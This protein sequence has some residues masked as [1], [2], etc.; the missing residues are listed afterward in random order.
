VHKL[1]GSADTAMKCNGSISLWFV[2]LLTA[3]SD[4][5]EETWRTV[6]AKKPIFMQIFVRK[7]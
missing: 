7:S 6:T 4:G 2:L 1:S 3:N 5:I